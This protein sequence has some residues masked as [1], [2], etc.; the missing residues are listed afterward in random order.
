MKSNFQTLFLIIIFIS[1]SCSYPEILSDILIYE[2]DFETGSLENIDGGYINEYNNSNVIGNFNNDGFRIH[3]NELQSHNYISI[4]FDLYIHGSWDGNFN[5]F[6]PDFPDLWSMEIRPDMSDFQD[7]DS[8]IFSTT[9]SNSPCFDNYCLHQ[10]YPNPY[11]F[12][13][14]PQLG[15][16][17][18]ELS[19][20]CLADGWNNVKTS[21]YKI[22]KTFNHSGGA[23]I[24]GFYDKLY[25]PNAIDSHGKV[26]Q[27]CDE[28]WSM[29]NIKIRLIQIK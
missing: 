9:F 2:N 25:Q 5:G 10:S 29:D 7:P 14:N 26:I 21:L 11:P 16:L 12:T 24:I 19:E 4:S 27:K 17:K 8:Q 13:N 6:D 28:S 23:F 20:V 18:T 22:E 15:A 1:N 3:L